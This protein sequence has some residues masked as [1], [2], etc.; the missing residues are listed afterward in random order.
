MEN[1]IVVD[2]LASELED[3]EAAKQLRAELAMIKSRIYA[4]GT[5]MNSILIMQLKMIIRGLIKKYNDAGLLQG[6]NITL[7]LKGRGRQA[8]FAFAYSQRLQYLIQSVEDAA[9][10]ALKAKAEAVN[11]NEINKEEA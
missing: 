1:V 3:F 6:E 4:S 2:S 8:G 5:V 9:L 10:E 11:A 7:V